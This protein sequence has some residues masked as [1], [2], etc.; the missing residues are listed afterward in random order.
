MDT[1]GSTPITTPFSSSEKMQH[2][3]KDFNENGHD[4]SVKT[5][6]GWRLAEDVKDY[7]MN[8]QASA[9]RLGVTWRDLS[10]EVVPSD[11]R[12]QENVISQFNVPQLVKD[13]RRKPALKP[14]LESSSGCVRPGEML[15][16]LGRPGSGCSTL[17]KMLANKRNGY[18]VHFLLN[19]QPKLIKP[20]QI[21]KGPWRCSLWLPRYRTS[22][23][24]FRQYRH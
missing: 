2:D 4:G 14:I 5:Q 7:D 22:Q 13:L 6:V 16:V 9:R 15:L 20:Q 11:E 1:H 17:L 8:N 18:V 12:L 3:I 24:I 10:V 21:R 23:A 19:M